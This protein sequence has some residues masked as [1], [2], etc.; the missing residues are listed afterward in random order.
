MGLEAAPKAE[1]Y[2]PIRQANFGF[3]WYA[4]KELLI[5]TA[6]APE[7]IV[8]DMRKIIRSVDPNLPVSHI[9]TF[10]DIRARETI[11]RR[12]TTV[13]LASFAALALILAATGIYGVLSY[14]VNQHF[15]EFG[16]R[17]ALGA[18]PISI[19]VLILRRGMSLVLRGV[20]FGLAGALAV[21][22]VLQ[23]VLFGVNA[24]DPR[25]F[26]AV[27]SILILTALAACAVPGWKAMRVNPLNALRY[28]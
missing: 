10:E 27:A 23:S 18:T 12:M 1:M 7:T 9:M 6:K 28:E 25:T 22:G 16:V 19:L 13:L 2:F 24:R 17:L 3:S 15:P 8:G 20:L 14:F 26:V 21:T 5:R 4:P 11:Q